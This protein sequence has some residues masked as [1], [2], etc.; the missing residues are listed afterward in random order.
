MCLFSIVLDIKYRLD[1]Q[2]FSNKLDP[3]NL[4][5]P[6]HLLMISSLNLWTC[7]YIYYAMKIMITPAITHYLR[8]KVR[9]GSKK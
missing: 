1:W 4:T 9:Q 5:D 3:Q 8:I 6:N 2:G 7:E